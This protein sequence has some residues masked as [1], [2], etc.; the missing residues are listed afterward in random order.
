MNGGALL[1]N[2]A[3]CVQGLRNDIKGFIENE[4]LY[5]AESPVNSGFTAPLQ[6]NGVCLVFK[7]M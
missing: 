1:L 7:Y 3:P 2:C 5:T 4:N 6:K